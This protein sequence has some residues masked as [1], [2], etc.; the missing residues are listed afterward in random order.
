M[1][2]DELLNASDLVAAKKHDTFHSEVVTGKAGGL[3]TGANIDYATNAVTAQ[4]QKTLPKILNDLDWSY[5]GLFAD[6]VTFTDKTDFAVDAVG[7][8]WI[9]TGS[10]PFSATAGT[11]PSEPTY[12]VVHVKSASAISNANGGSV[13]DFIDSQTFPNVEAML[14]FNGLQAGQ[15]VKTLGYYEAGDGGHAYYRITSTPKY[16]ADGLRDHTL[17]NGLV[18]ELQPVLGAYNVKSCGAKGD[19]VT[20]DTASF[21]AATLH[22]IPYDQGGLPFNSSIVKRD[23]IVDGTDYS[24]HLL[25][26]VYIRKGQHLRGVGLGAARITVPVT[27]GPT[28]F[29]LGYGLIFGVETIDAGGLPPSISYLATEG[30]RPSKPLIDAQSVAGASVNNLFITS[31]GIGISGAGGDI[32]ITNCTLDICATAIRVIGSRNVINSC[33]FFNNNVD[34]SIASKSYDWII[35]DCLFAYYKFG[36]I[37]FNCLTDEIKNI[38]I[39]NCHFLLNDQYATNVGTIDIQTGNPSINITNTKFNNHKGYAIKQTTTGLVKASVKDCHF[40]IEKTNP[41]YAQSTTAA[42]LLIG[43]GDWLIEGNKFTNLLGE[44]ITVKTPSKPVIKYNTLVTTQT[45]PKPLVSFSGTVS[46]LYVGHN[47][48]DGLADILQKDALFNEFSGVEGLTTNRFNNYVTEGGR[49]ALKIPTV[50]ADSFMVKVTYNGNSAS[51]GKYRRSATFLIDKGVAF[52]TEVVNYVKS[53]NLSG[54]QTGTIPA[55]IDLQVAIGVVG[56]PVTDP[57]TASSYRDVVL[58]VPGDAAQVKIETA[59]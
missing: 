47:Y 20:D 44:N 31:A 2:A 50:N 59:V 16:G 21:N 13:Q 11:V 6:G 9:Y 19:G 51:S 26:T 14:A 32:S 25:G 35:S 52:T 23:V 27:P 30:G 28:T 46:R 36:S 4:V 55:Q 54:T 56:G 45:S 57:V 34:L 3:S 40:D 38:S 33:S 12:Q 49:I 41:A 39:D 17:T 10:L 48:I 58:S 43:E 8:Q 1:M 22:D 24:Y 7:T 37:N 15:V 18:A 5:V 29:L 53:I 42:G